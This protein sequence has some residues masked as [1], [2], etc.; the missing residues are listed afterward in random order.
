[1]SSLVTPSTVKRAV[2]R[3]LAE[4]VITLTQARTML[5]QDMGYRVDK[6]TVCRWVNRGVGGVKLEAARVGNSLLTSRQ[7][8]SRFIVARTEKTVGTGAG[9]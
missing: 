7:A 4:D 2:Q 5:A 8:L 3:V 1:M 9:R 6:S